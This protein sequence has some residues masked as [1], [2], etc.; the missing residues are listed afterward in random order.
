M[1]TVVRESMCPPKPDLEV[2]EISQATY[3]RLRLLEEIVSFDTPR[4]ELIFPVVG[5]L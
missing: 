5:R 3:R 2:Q 1:V 4:L